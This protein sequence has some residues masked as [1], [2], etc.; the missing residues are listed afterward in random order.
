M[1]KIIDKVRQREFDAMLNRKALERASKLEW[2]AQGWERT[3]KHPAEP[4]AFGGVN[5]GPDM[6]RPWQIGSAYMPPLPKSSN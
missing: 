1:G 3:E 6:Y 5:G 4:F 2:V